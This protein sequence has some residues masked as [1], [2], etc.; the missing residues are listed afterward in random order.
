MITLYI[1]DQKSV[2]NEVKHD[3][4]F[5]TYDGF[6]LRLSVKVKHVGTIF[7]TAIFSL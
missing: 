2:S 1:Y 5:L 4:D 3:R 7:V 6:I